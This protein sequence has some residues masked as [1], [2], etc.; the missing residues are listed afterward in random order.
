VIRGGKILTATS[1]ETAL[2]RLEGQI[3][4]ATLPREQVAG[5]KA[6]GKVISTQMAGART[7]VR[8]LSENGKPAEPF[9]PATATLEDH[10]FIAVN[11]V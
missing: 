8:M 9:V 11:Q 3:W 7:R 6:S 2:T 5:L 10:Y 4:E 1:P